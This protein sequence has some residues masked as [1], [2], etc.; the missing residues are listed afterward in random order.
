ME[1]SVYEFGYCAI[2]GARDVPV[3]ARFVTTQLLCVHQQKAGKI[4][5]KKK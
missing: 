3:M 1:E 2:R 5:R 4:V